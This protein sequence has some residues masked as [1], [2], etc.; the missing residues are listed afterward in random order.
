MK[1]IEKFSGKE[2]IRNFELAHVAK[3][4]SEVLTDMD[5]ELTTLDQRLDKARALK[6]AMMQELFTKKTRLA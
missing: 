5:V 1:N 3:T 4:I 2:P 6:T